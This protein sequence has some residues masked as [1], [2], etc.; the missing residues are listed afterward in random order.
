MIDARFIEAK[1]RAAKYVHSWFGEC[2]LICRN[3]VDGAPGGRRRRQSHRGGDRGGGNATA[4]PATRPPD[5]HNENI[6]RAT[7]TVPRFE[8]L[9]PPRLSPHVQPFVPISMLQKDGHSAP[10]ATPVIKPVT[11][12]QSLEEETARLSVRDESQSPKHGR[13]RRRNRGKSNMSKHSSPQRTFHARTSS[14]DQ[15]VSTTQRS[16]GSH[17]DQAMLSADKLDTTRKGVLPI[18]IPSKLSPKP[19]TSLPVVR[20]PEA[21]RPAPSA[22]SH[23]SMNLMRSEDTE[24]GS[25]ISRGAVQEGRLYNHKQ[26]EKLQSPPKPRDPRPQPPPAEE[27]PQP[28]PG[29]L[30]RIQPGKLEPPKPA[31]QHRGGL[32]FIDTNAIKST[33]NRGPKQRGNQSEYKRDAIPLR[34][35]PE[36]QPRTVWNPDNIPPAEKMLHDGPK[37]EISAEDILREVKAAYQEIQNLERK[38]ESIYD[39]QADGVEM[40]R[41]RSRSQNDPVTWTNYCKTHNE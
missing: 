11:P 41:I 19:E 34:K 29:G 16:T 20:L 5:A 40:S 25:Y 6:N 17:N 22:T 36:S 14:E 37:F 38:V 35:E 21:V 4:T 23:D 9:G 33:N 31:P 24:F 28:R 32:L 10:T 1:R 2:V 12:M 39:S 18:S 26:I 7:D 8:S 3:T 27:K 13:Q 15:R 30:L